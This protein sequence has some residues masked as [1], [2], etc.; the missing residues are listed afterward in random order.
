MHALSINSEV[1]VTML[2]Q[3]VD[4]TTTAGVNWI[5]AG[6]NWIFIVTVTNQVLVI[7]F[8][9]GT[10]SRFYVQAN[11]L[12]AYGAQILAPVAVGPSESIG[13]IIDYATHVYSQVY[14]TYGVLN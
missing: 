2:H 10:H 12:V 11:K 1:T 6:V 4:G 5:T 14:T 3:P 7:I 9:T 8:Y 13:T